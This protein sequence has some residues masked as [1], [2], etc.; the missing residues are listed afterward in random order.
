M[1]SVTTDFGIQLHVARAVARRPEQAAAI[2]RTWMRV[3]L[4]TAGIAVAAVAAGLLARSP[5]TDYALAN[6]SLRTSLRR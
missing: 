4:W 3:R 1:V 6:P 2:L 5:G